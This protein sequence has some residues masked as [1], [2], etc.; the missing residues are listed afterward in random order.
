MRRIAHKVARSILDMDATELAAAIKRQEVSSLEATQAYISHVKEVNP[1]LNCLVEDRFQ[2]AIS[3][4]KLADERMMQGNGEGQLFGV[5]ISVKESFDII[6]MRTTGGLPNREAEVKNHDA[7]VVARLKSE[8]AIILGK[9]NTPVLCFCQETN[10]K[11]YGR[12]NNPWNMKRTAGGSSGGE[13]VI[14]AAGGAAVGIGSDIGGSIRYPAHFNGVIGF[15]SGNVQVSDKGSFPPI[16]HPLQ[17]RML[18]IG[19]L[20]KSVRDAQLMNEIVALNIPESKTIKLKEFEIVLPIRD[21]SYP[22]NSETH[23]ILLRVKNKLTKQ[24]LVNGMQPPYY[25][26]TAL[27]WQLIMSIN[28]ADEMAKIAFGGHRIKLVR[29]YLKEKLFKKSELHDYF[30]W[31]LIG[32]KIFKPNVAKQLQIE[33]TIK[34][35]DEELSEFL[36]KKIIILPVYHSPAPTHGQVYSEIFSIQ[37]TYLHYMPFV[38]YANVWG[39]PA[40]TIPVGEDA[41]GMPIA[42]QV[43]SKVGNEDAIFQVGKIIES[44]FRG[45]KRKKFAYE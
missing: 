35:G 27:L 22:V 6:G 8:G 28:G 5:P 40:L 37:K 29:E 2:E 38:A 19:A 26:D 45:Y 21:L 4:A 15:K 1:L 14:I 17:R 33:Q 44:A 20:A 16:N 39:L 18:G 3:E 30:T 41:D 43:I 9:T 32:A 7:S 42:I 34:K 24:F 12:T 23:S 31:A 11:L 25:T 13:G 36:K 10:N